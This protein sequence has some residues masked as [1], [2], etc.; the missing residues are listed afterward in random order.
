LTT[1]PDRNG[2]TIV[3]T[4][5]ITAQ[6]GSPFI[7][8]E[9]S[10]DAPLDLLFRAHVEPELLK[11]WLGPARYEMTIEEYEV[12]DGGRWRFT[13]HDDSTGN[14]YGF[15]GVFHGDPSTAGILQTF[16][17]DGAP[18]HVSLDA[19]TFEPNGGQTTIRIHSVYQSVEA[20]DAMI[21]SGMEGG[22]NE[23][24]DRLD[25]LVSQLAAVA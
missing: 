22:V 16:E 14:A 17:F 8:I 4:T 2:E 19:L 12:R 9:R 15:H 23:G 1:H 3:G 13:H 24:Y 11:Q 5:R 7:D 18:G 6:P 10:F 21:E 20:R 25:A